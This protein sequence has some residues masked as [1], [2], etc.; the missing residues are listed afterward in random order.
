MGKFYKTLYDE[1]EIYVRYLAWLNATPDTKREGELAR[2]E[3]FGNYEIVYPECD[4]NHILNYLFEI[5]L[6]EGDKPLSHAE[7][8]S[9]QSN[10]GIELQAYEARFLKRLSEIYLAASHEMKKIDAVNPWEDAPKYMS[11]N[12]L[13]SQRSKEAIRRA[14]EI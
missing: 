2:R 7:I 1:L 9:W 8:A 4:A 5:G 6:T 11:H 13:A 10:T 14:A 12:F 3:S